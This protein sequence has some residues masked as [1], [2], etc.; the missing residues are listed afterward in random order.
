ML[1]NVSHADGLAEGYAGKGH[2]RKYKPMCGPGASRVPDVRL[3]LR[4]PDN[5]VSREAT[6]GGD[7]IA[8]I[9]RGLAILEAFGPTGQWLGNQEIA[10]CTG[11]PKPTVTRLT[12]TLMKEGFLNHSARLRKYRLA[13]AV[14]GLG[15]VTMDSTD[16]AAI[17]RPL[18]Q[19]L[20]DECGV[21]VSLAGRNGLDIS[22]V[23]NCHSTTNAVTLGLNVG[24]RFPIE[25][26]PLGLALLSGLPS[27]ERDYLLDHIRLRYNQ[28]YRVSLRLRVADAT[29]Q[30]VQKGYY[31]TEWG[32]QITVASAPLNVADRP[33]MSIG[34]AGPT[35][36]LVRAKL[37]EQIGPKLV[38]LVS[39]LQNH[40]GLVVG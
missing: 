27:T 38:Q 40:V 39:T 3:V 2:F 17:A 25:A 4:A 26:C 22:L 1:L 8:P 13:S 32:P 28:E 11:I 12:Q 34:C 10:T 15:Y 31:V 7:I 24:S 35:K 5:L 6:G 23:E 18:M 29:M 30:V 37:R 9:E 21:F 36:S 20:G 33:P 14:L 16:I 19:E